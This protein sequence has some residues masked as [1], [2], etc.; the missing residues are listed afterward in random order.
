MLISENKNINLNNDNYCY[1]DMSLYI[2]A[3][4]VVENSRI[5][6][7][8]VSINDLN[9][10]VEDYGCDYEDAFYAVSETN[11][12]NPEDLAVMV[13]DWKLIET[14]E[15]ANMVPNIVVKPI[16]EANFAYQFVN[17]C[18]SGYCNTGDDQYLYNIIDED[19]TFVQRHIKNG[20]KIGAVLGTL[21]GAYLGRKASH[22]VKVNAGGAAAGAAL[23]ALAGGYGGLGAA[24]WRA[25]FNQKMYKINQRAALTTPVFGNVVK[26]AKK[27][28]PSWISKKIAAI[29]HWIEVKLNRNKDP[30]KQNLIQ[31]LKTKLLGIIDKLKE[32]LHIKTKKK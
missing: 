8:I 7:V 5:G 15:L 9:S 17:E 14:P 25:N 2:N 3:I 26:E 23:G 12:I 11:Q 18:I 32:I 6:A 30:K 28:D 13:E 20:A 27:K 29:R 4:P 16:S 21:G 31:R 1:D 22:S 19:G 24:K 10:I